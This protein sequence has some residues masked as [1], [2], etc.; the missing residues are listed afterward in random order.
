MA[1]CDLAQTKYKLVDLS[2]SPIA[3]NRMVC[4]ASERFNHEKSF[5]LLHLWDCHCQP[6]AF[7][8]E[9]PSAN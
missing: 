9:M 8:I 4:D 2:P 1:G 5:P 6:G 3:V 7:F